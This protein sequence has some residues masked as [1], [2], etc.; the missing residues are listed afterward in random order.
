MPV[1]G[2]DLGAIY[3][4]KESYERAL[5]SFIKA[6]TIDPDME[7]ALRG[8]GISYFRLG[9]IS[10]SIEILRKATEVDSYNPLV[11]ESLIN[12]YFFTQDFVGCKRALIEAV[13]YHP[14]NA[15][16]WHLLGNIHEELDN[17]E[18]AEIAYKRALDLDPEIES[19]VIRFKTNELFSI[20][21]QSI[22][23][24]VQ[25]GSASPKEI[26]DLLADVSILYRLMGGSGISFDIEGRITIQS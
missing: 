23:F 14:E 7:H 19:K 15:K 12:A 25:P 24:L 17:E 21:F 4:Q 1:N 9:R 18:E 11:W 20:P 10:E 26:A 22:Q 8:L 3:L 5:D 6:T 16:W 13:Y 2:A